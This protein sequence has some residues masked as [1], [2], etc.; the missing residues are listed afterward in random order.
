M[1]IHMM[2]EGVVVSHRSVPISPRL[3]QCHSG[4]SK[5]GDWKLSALGVVPGDSTEVGGGNTYKQGESR[6]GE[7]RRGEVRKWMN[8]PLQHA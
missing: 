6:R 8:V 1:G 2:V 5:E 3:I 7:E 4:L